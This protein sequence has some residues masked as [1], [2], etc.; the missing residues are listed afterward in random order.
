M[1][2]LNYYFEDCGGDFE[3]DVD[4]KMLL[5]ALSSLLRNCETEELIEIMIEMDNQ[6]PAEY[7]EEDLLE[8]FKD[9][10]YEQAKD[11]YEYHKDPLGYNGMSEEDFK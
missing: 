3:F 11:S 6:T 4:D 2:K 8:Y 7:F 10:A 5:S 9:E 1:T